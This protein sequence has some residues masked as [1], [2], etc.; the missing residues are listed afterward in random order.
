MYE[1]EQE[2]IEE[3]EEEEEKR[4]LE[5]LVTGPSCESHAFRCLK[6]DWIAEVVII[7]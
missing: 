1:V 5:Q 7:L 6:D 2:A 4:G 3:G